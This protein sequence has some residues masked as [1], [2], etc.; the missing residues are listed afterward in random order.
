MERKFIKFRDNVLGDVSSRQYLKTPYLVFAVAILLTVGTTFFFYKSAE[1]NDR[2]RFQNDVTT[3]QSTINNRLDAYIT[4]L[5]SGRGFL[6]ASKAQGKEVTRETYAT[7]IKSLELEDQF[8]GAQ[9]I[10][11]IKRVKPE[12]L[13]ALTSKMRAEGDEDFTVDPAAVPNSEA[14]ILLYLEPQSKDLNSKGPGYIVSNEPLRLA[15][16]QK[17]S[18]SGKAT[19]SEKLIMVQWPRTPESPRRPGFQIF[20]PLYR[21]G[22]VP[23][24][25]TQRKLEVESLLYCPFRANRFIEE[26]QKIGQVS[27]ISFAIYDREVAPDNLLGDSQAPEGTSPV[28]NSASLS[29]ARR[30]YD[31]V[32]YE[33]TVEND[34]GGEKWQIRYQSLPAFHS[35]S[36][37]GWTL[38]IFFFGL[39]ISLVLFFITLSQAKAH[40]SLG[41]IADDLARSERVKDEFIAVVSHELRTPLNSIA[42][43]ANILR[44]RNITD[45][46][47][48][49]A[50]DIIDKNLRSQAG[51]VE[52][53]IVFSDINAGKGNLHL[54][55]VN[56]SLL[57][58]KV[59][60]EFL[61]QAKAKNIS[62][63]KEDTSGGKMVA[64]D[65][66]KLEK[67]L[68]SVLS[69]S[70]KFTPAKGMISLEVKS[71]DKDVELKIRD[72]GLGIHA[73]ILPH[74]FDLFKQGDSSTVRR[75]G[76]LGLGMALSRHIVTLHGGT[77]DAESPGLDKG[78]TFIVRLPIDETGIVA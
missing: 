26:V 39:G 45:E 76:G 25:E 7:F 34:V 35:N 67:V 71:V 75:Y 55:P 44:N 29:L 49:K 36:A 33:K 6:E 30:L 5:K 61:P 47:R 41:I 46:T 11:Y 72:N 38:V 31:T 62:F 19:L 58:D 15:S 2:S 74:V 12:E 16:I 32:R 17:A 24:S 21:S 50:L 69:N 54:Q 48:K 14:Y 4:L 65:E 40:N 77:L 78:S 42:G 9:G 22:S 66:T 51:L 53:M 64:A 10:G 70:L 68:Q 63:V 60:N 57:V 3:I 52:D 73:Q 28:N 13:T 23:E 1:A 8:K 27:D 56:F 20:I 43:G 59:F 18:A 37:T